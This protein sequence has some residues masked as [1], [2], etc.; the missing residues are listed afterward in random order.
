[1]KYRIV[2]MPDGRDPLVFEG[3]YRSVADAAF[4]ALRKDEVDLGRWDDPVEEV[5]V[6]VQL[7]DRKSRRSTS[8]CK[9]VL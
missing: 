7:I 5:T 4:G 8:G 1:M 9:R 2:I 6:K 3:N